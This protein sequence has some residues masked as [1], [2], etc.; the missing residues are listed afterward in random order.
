MKAAKSE[1]NRK[2]SRVMQKP[3]NF[4]FAEACVKD[5]KKKKSTFAIQQH[6][7]QNFAIILFIDDSDQKLFFVQLLSIY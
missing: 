2:L 3:V 7:L 5:E 6:S 4:I 1:T